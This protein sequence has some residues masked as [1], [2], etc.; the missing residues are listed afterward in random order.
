MQSHRV[1]DGSNLAYSTTT[2][3]DDINNFNDREKQGAPPSPS[4]PKACFDVQ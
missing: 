1:G 2:F 4:V 3:V